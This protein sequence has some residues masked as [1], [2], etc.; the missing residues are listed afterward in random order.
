[1][2]SS[3]LE[4]TMDQFLNEEHIRSSKPQT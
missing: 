4:P 2:V 1:M 3:G